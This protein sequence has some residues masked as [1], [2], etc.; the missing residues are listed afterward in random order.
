MTSPRVRPVLSPESEFFWRSGADGLLRFLRCRDCSYWIHPP[1]PVCP[2]CLSPKIGPEPV[3]GAG[4]I[5]SFTI[6][7]QAWNPA[8][9]VPYTII[10]VE[11]DEQTGLRLVSNLPGVD[12]DDVAIGQRVQVR[13]ESLDE[14]LYVPVFTLDR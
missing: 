4:T 1:G 9:P 8:V 5:V 7:H 14:D 12:P 2:E 10:L 11:L 13:F 3:S 6:N